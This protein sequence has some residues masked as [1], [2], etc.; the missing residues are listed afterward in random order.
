MNL[1]PIRQFPLALLL[2]L[3]LRPFRLPLPLLPAPAEAG[4][5]PPAPCPRFTRCRCRSLDVVLTRDWSRREWEGGS[6]ADHDRWGALVETFWGIF[7]RTDFGSLDP[8]FPLLF[9]FIPTRTARRCAGGEKAPGAPAR[10]PHL[11]TR[12]P[13]VCVFFGSGRC[14]AE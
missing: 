14:C 8:V 13:C 6:E 12:A 10:S 1:G 4:P 5:G 11:F 9:I 7:P 3:L 2:N